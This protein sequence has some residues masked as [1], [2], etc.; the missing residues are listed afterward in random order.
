MLPANKAESTTLILLGGVLMFAVGALYLFFEKSIIADTQSKDELAEPGLDD[1]SRVVLSVQLGLVLLSMIVTKS[2]IGYIQARQ[3]LPLGVLVVGRA[4]LLVSLLLPQLH[5]LYPN[6][7]YIH[8]LVVIFLQFAPTFIILT[9]SYEGLFY[10]AFCLCLFSWMR[11]EHQVYLHTNAHPDTTSATPI[12]PAM[13]AAATRLDSIKKG[14]YR[15]LTLADARIALFFFFFIQ[16]AFFSASNIASVSSFSLDA[17]YRLIPIFDPFS[18]GALLMLKLMLPF[19]FLSS[20]FGLLNKRLGVA[21][22][23]LFMVVMAV[24]DVMTLNFFW[25]VK[26]EGSWLDI[27][28]TISHFVIASLLGV[29]VS[30]LEVVSEVII[31]GV[32]FGGKKGGNRSLVQGNGNGNENRTGTGNGKVNGKMD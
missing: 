18:Q 25:L 20:V 6:S 12:T 1:K 17:V 7:N 23:A 31:R 13:D 22:S 26:D 32:E 10:F 19:A 28:T 29:F 21:P 14:D 30:G 8:R 5:R 4:T 16:S 2:S 9:I 3:G 24:S 11:L 15:S 27:G